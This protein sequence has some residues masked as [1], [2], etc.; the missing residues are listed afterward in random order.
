MRVRRNIDAAVWFAESI[1]P[2][3]KKEVPDAGFWIVGSNPNQEVL[4]LNSI[5]GVKVVGTVNKIEEYYRMG[6]VFVAPYHFGAGTKLKLLE[7]MASG[8]PIVSTNIGCRGI[9]VINKRHIL[10]ADSDSEFINSVV[11]LL[12]DKNLSQMLAK[13]AIALIKDKY[14]W[15]KIVD[16]IEPKI[17]EI[18]KKSNG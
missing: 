18:V 11:N 13:N 12:K 15:K 17:L 2:Q 1:F 8:I 4:R 10:I 5:N 3:V 7:A 6:K 16:E 9:E 14:C